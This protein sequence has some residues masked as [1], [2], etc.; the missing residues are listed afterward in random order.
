MKLLGH[1]LAKNYRLKEAETLL[2]AAVQLRPQVSGAPDITFCDTMR[3][4]SWVLELQK[5]HEEATDTSQYAVESSRQL[6]GPEHPVTLVLKSSLARRLYARGHHLESVRIM[7]V[8]LS[9]QCSLIGETYPGTLFTIR[10]LA[11]IL[12]NIGRIEEA[13]MWYEKWFQ[14]LFGEYWNDHRQTI[15]SCH[16]LGICYE[17]QGRYAEAVLLYQQMM[18]KILTTQGDGH[19]SIKKVQSWI[20]N[21]QKILLV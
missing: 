20:D 9:Q 3:P 10:R 14:G 11:K 21:A 16:K 15:K 18:E 17:E 7:R 19:P 1:S 12:P 6:L 13:T 8:V 2:R 5:C 4:L